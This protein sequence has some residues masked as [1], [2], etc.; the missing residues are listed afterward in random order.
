VLAQRLEISGIAEHFA[1]LHGEVL[2]H[3]PEDLGL[4]QHAILE[5]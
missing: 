2:Q 4:V 3:L 5:L 1:H